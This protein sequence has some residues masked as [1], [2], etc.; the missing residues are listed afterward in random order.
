MKLHSVKSQK[1]AQ[2]SWILFFSIDL[3]KDMSNTRWLNHTSQLQHRWTDDHYTGKFIKFY[4]TDEQ[5][6]EMASSDILTTAT[7]AFCWPTL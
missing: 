7:Y 3:S 2:F 4:G 1:Y 5:V 6:I